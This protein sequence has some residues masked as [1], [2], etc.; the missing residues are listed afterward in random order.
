MITK[1][2]YTDYR[3]YD[4]DVPHDYIKITRYESGKADVLEINAA[5]AEFYPEEGQPIKLL[6]DGEVRFLGR[7]FAYAR[8]HES[9]SVTAYDNLMYF[10]SKDTVY[11]SGK[12]ACDIIR[13]LCAKL[14]ISCG[15][16]IDTAYV[17]PAK[18]YENM[19]FFDIVQ[20]VLDQTLQITGI[21]YILF[22]NNGLI[23]L[24]K[25]EYKSQILDITD[26]FLISKVKSM[27]A[28]NVYNVVNAYQV[29][30]YGNVSNNYAV[31]EKSVA[32]FGKITKS[33]RVDR[34]LSAAQCRLA[35]WNMIDEYKNIMF[36]QEVEIILPDFVID[37]ADV[38]SLDGTLYTV[39]QCVMVISSTKNTYYLTMRQ[40]VE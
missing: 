7:V 40:G 23:S 28:Q 27:N 21:R 4:Y 20:D 31:H 36:S 39:S 13:D 3:G 12:K 1:I 22:D 34:S 9:V 29:D 6:I 19:T 15:D 38:V 2:I 11:Y 26:D 35:A 33:V 5:F 8:T 10:K 16:I 17:I 32:C 14:G 25:Y 18:L 30:K 37:V 24:K